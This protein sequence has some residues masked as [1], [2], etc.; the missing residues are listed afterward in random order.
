MPLA[1]KQ[2]VKHHVADSTVQ[3]QLAGMGA[4]LA[5][6]AK[7]S[8]ILYGIEF[9]NDLIGGHWFTWLLMAEKG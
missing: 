1:P 5:E 6:M 9:E 4:D 2:A 3:T 7:K 8:S